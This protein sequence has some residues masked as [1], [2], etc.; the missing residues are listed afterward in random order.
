MHSKLLLCV[1]SVIWMN[2]C[3]LVLTVQACQV[4]G[5]AKACSKPVLR[6]GGRAGGRRGD[7]LNRIL[8]ASDR[9]TEKKRESG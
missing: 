4:S 1:H 2:M 6:N 9:D 7:W 8:E 3:Y 5:L